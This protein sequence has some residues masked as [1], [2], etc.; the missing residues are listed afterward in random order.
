[1]PVLAD[2]RQPVEI[3][4][5]RK[6][7]GREAWRYV[8]TAIWFLYLIGPLSTFVTGHVLRVNGGSLL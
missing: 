4:F 7:T 5:Q 2:P 8:F 3:P 1:M 6:L